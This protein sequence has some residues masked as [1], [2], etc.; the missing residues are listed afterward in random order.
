VSFIE[1]FCSSE[2]RRLAIFSLL[3]LLNLNLKLVSISNKS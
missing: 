3:Y 2:F 1:W